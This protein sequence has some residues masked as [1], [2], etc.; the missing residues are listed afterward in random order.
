MCITLTQKLGLR[1]YLGNLIISVIC[2]PMRVCVSL[3]VYLSTATIEYLCP[4]VCF[5]L[6]VCVCMCACLC[7]CVCVCE[8]VIVHDNSKINESV[9]LKLEH[10]VVYGNSS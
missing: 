1:V 7:G 9:S 5:C 4:S 2:V 10:I 8:C 6:C 3:C